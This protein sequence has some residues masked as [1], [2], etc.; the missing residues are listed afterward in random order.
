MQQKESNE[1]LEMEHS[2]DM[3][4]NDSRASTTLSFVSYNVKAGNSL[5]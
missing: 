3:R 5:L 1:G 4:W 2:T